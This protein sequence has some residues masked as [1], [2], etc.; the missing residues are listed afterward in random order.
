MPNQTLT[1]GTIPTSNF[2][3][4]ADR[5]QARISSKVL[6]IGILGRD[7]PASVAS[8]TGLGGVCIILA[9]LNEIGRDW[10]WVKAM[11]SDFIIWY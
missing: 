7:G 5:L 8:S 3:S 1:V 4:R 6:I 10:A 2:R 11:R 9:P